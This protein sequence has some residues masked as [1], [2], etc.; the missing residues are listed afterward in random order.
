MTAT[1]GSITTNTNLTVNPSLVSIAVTPATP[2]I[3]VNGTQQFIAT[4]TYS[5]SGQ[6]VITGSVTW[7][8]SDTS[9]ATINSAGLA[10]GVA[11]GTVTIQASS[12]SINGSTTLTVD[13][14]LVSLTVS[15]ADPIIDINTT[16]Q[17]TATANFSD[18]SAQD[19]TQL[20]SWS[21]PDCQ[22]WFD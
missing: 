18:G 17:F 11:A 5:D 8:S 14:I 10:T 4:G 9:L 22:R 6:Q 16:T 3:L 15:A 12:G 13:P 2:S 21:A 1:S 7:S 19:Y 20:V